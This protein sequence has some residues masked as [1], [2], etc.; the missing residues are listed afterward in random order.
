M[1]TE[2]GYSKEAGRPQQYARAAVKDCK[3]QVQNF[4]PSRLIQISTMVPHQ[5]TSRAPCLREQLSQPIVRRQSPPVEPQ[6]LTAKASSKAKQNQSLNYKSPYQYRKQQ[7]HIDYVSQLFHETKGEDEEIIFE[8]QAQE[9]RRQRL[10]E[11]RKCN[12]R[13]VLEEQAGVQ[14]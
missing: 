13:S 6:A 3:Y 5:P 2:P 11:L 12:R 14:G 8:D 10:Y 9:L 1:A 4:A 7:F